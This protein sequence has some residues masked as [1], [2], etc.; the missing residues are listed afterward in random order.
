MSSSHPFPP[1]YDDDPRS[2]RQRPAHDQMILPRFR[3]PGPEK[4]VP[5]NAGDDPDERAPHTMLNPLGKVR[6]ANEVAN[7]KPKSAGN[8][9]LTV[10]GHYPLPAAWADEAKEVEAL[11][12]NNEKK[13][14]DPELWSPTVSDF[15]A[16]SAGGTLCADFKILL[17]DVVFTESAAKRPPGSVKRLNIITHGDRS[18]IAM[19]GEVI[20][21]PER[22]IVNL[23]ARGAITLENLEHLLTP[24]LTI[25][26]PSGD[27]NL[28]FTLNDVHKALAPEA[29]LFLYSCRSGAGKEL[30]DKL[31]N[32]LQIAVHGFKEQIAFCPVFQEKP[33]RVVDRKWIAVGSCAATMEGKKRT[34][35]FHTLKPDRSSNPKP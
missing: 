18:W 9:E 1:E 31:A 4:R 33:P 5:T 21:T 14:G 19:Q 17:A 12:K 16:I 34:S 32:V 28:R 2:D 25:T 13:Q 23:K 6:T 24:G 29:E 30:R 11:K 3:V 10:Y 8:V 27:K 35:D 22:V 15:Q 26:A 7:K 20:P